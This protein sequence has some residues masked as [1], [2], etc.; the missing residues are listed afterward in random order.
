MS[1]PTV[2]YAGQ[3]DLMYVEE[4]LSL[5]LADIKTGRAVYEKDKVQLV[6]YAAASQRSPDRLEV[7]RVDPDQQEWE[8]SDSDS[9]AEEPQLL[10]GKFLE[11]R[12]ALG[13]ISSLAAKIM[14]ESTAE[15]G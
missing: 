4:D 6:A 8:V 10:W 13:D 2:G 5:V 7:L 3:F 15:L 1:N 12:A 9:W 11:A 14:D